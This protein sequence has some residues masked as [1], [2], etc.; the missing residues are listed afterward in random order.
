LIEVVPVG[1]AEAVIG[2]EVC[3]ALHPALQLG[4]YLNL[5]AFRWTL[6][7]RDR[8]LVLT[9]HHRISDDF[10]QLTEMWGISLLPG[11]VCLLR[12]HDIQ[13]TGSLMKCDANKLGKTENKPSTHLC[14]CQN[15][16]VLGQVWRACEHDQPALCKVTGKVERKV[17][18][19]CFISPLV[20]A[21]PLTEESSSFLILA[22]RRQQHNVHVPLCELA[23]E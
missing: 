17:K 9:G 8:L 19:T 3:A 4:V 20:A 21:A 11:V 12:L 1:L 14:G 15:E 6:P 18:F 22:V 23:V 13:M 16:H 10:L 2:V 7:K 5:Q